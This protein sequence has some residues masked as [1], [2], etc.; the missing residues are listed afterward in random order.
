ME[1]PKEMEAPIKAGYMEELRFAKRQQ[2]YVA[3]AAI[4]LIA[5]AFHLAQSMAPL[6]CWEKAVASNIVLLVAAG[7]IWLMFDLQ[8]HLANTRK[9]LDPQDDRPWWRGAPIAFCLAI[10][11]LIS[12]VVV[13]YALWRGAKP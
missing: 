8:H 5:G 7:G 4:G 3:A 11:Q 2:W 10:V 9:V 6:A 1:A 13:V 12:A